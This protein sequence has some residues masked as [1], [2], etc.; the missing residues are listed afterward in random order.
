MRFNDNSL[1]ETQIQ[2]LFRW[3]KRHDINNWEEDGDGIH[4]GYYGAAR[5]PI[6]LRG[7]YVSL[8]GTRV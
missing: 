3:F 4:P 7:E 5:I 2:G 1:E 6:N 8:I